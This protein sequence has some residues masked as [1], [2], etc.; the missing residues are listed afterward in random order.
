M[1]KNITVYAVIMIIMLSVTI[2]L[3]SLYNLRKTGI[4][5]AI[6][7]AQSISEVVKS[8]LTAHMLNGNMDQVETFINSTSHIKNVDELWLVRSKH[9]NEQFPESNLRHPPRDEF[10]ERV[11]KTGRIHHYIEEGITNSTVRV[12]IPYNAIAEK[13]IDCLQCHNVSQGTTLGAVSIILDISTIKEIGIESIYV[14]LVLILTTVILFMLISRRLISPYLTL[15]DKFK[16]NVS[17]ATNGKFKRIN[18]PIGLSSE[19][20]KLTQEYNNLIQSFED[21]AIDIDKKL[22]GYVGY[23]ISSK[24]RNPL[25]DSKEIINNLSNLYQF[26]KQIELDSTK[27]EIYNRLAEVLLNK[28]KIKNFSFIEIDMKKYKQTKIKEVGHSLYCKDTILNNPE[29]CRA[30]RTKNDVMSVDFHNTCP[31]FNNDEKFYYCFNVDISQNLY[32]IINCVCD[33][34]EELERIKEQTVFVKSYLKESAPSIEVK[35]LMNALQES[36]FRDGLTGLYNRKF[37]EEYSKKMLPQL[38]RDNKKVGLLMLDMDHFKAVNDE[39]GHDIGDKVLKE[40]ARILNETV[41]ESDIIIRY[42]GEEFMVLLIGVNSEVDALNVAKKIGNNVRE[43]EIDV[44]AGAKLRKTV[45][46]GLSMYPDDANSFDSVIKNADIALYEAKNS[47]RDKVVRFK[48]EQI[49]SI[50]LF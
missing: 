28:F 47:G 33:T 8:G 1:K 25:K 14:I 34:K 19:M 44:Y 39:Y 2:S 27:E 13:G 42:G 15:F 36:A 35:L 17:Q 46:I 31:Y 29:L 37:L 30:A 3:F 12:T 48:E 18:P 11:L 6:H 4:E 5:S 20:V 24:E 10:D 26:K 9:L 50:D 45:S 49:S 16:L 7:N 32:L 40:L 41:R 21:T 38:K 22:Q 43:N 23:E